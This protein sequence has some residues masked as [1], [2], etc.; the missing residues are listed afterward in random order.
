MK[1][2]NHKGK[3]ATETALQLFQIMF[4]HE[5]QRR[6]RL[7]GRDI[8]CFA[9]HPGA[10]GRPNRAPGARLQRARAERLGPPLACSLH[11][12]RARMHARALRNAHENPTTPKAWLPPA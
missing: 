12:P 3:T 2:N 7:E 9:V 11:G 10:A 5:L 4:N 8:D 1:G 6:L